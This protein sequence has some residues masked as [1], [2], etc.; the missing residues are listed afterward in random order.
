MNSHRLRFLASLSER[1][2]SDLA[3]R[4]RD[5]DDLT[6]PPWPEPAGQTGGYEPSLEEIAGDEVA[7][8]PTPRGARIEAEQDAESEFVAQ[9]GAIAP[10]DGSVHSE[11]ELTPHHSVPW[12]EAGMP[13][14]LREAIAS[15]R[16][17]SHEMH[18]PPAGEDTM[19]GPA[20][21]GDD[22]DYNIDPLDDDAAYE[23][24]PPDDRLARLEDDAGPEDGQIGSGGHTTYEEPPPDDE[25]DARARFQ[26]EHPP[27]DD[28][29]AYE[30]SQAADELVLRDNDALDDDGQIG[31]GAH[32][33][34]E[35]SPPEHAPIP[36]DDDPAY[37]H[38]QIRLDDD[39]AYDEQAPVDG[40]AYEP[41]GLE[42]GAAQEETP[43][44]EDSD[45]RVPLWRRA[46]RRYGLHAAA[47]AVAIAFVALAGF[48]LGVLSGDGEVGGPLTR[49]S[50]RAAAPTEPA[51]LST[52]QNT[53]VAERDRPAELSELVTVRVAPAP[54]TAV[55]ESAPPARLTVNAPL[56]PPPKPA[57]RQLAA[58]EA[59]PAATGEAAPAA[60]G[61]TAPA[62][63]GETAPAATDETAPAATGETA[64]A[65]TDETAPAATGETAPAA[66]GEAAPADRQLAGV[67]EDAAAALLEAE[68]AEGA[69]GPFQPLFTK[70]PAARPTA[71][72]V[73]VHYS[74]SA[75]GAPATAMHLVRHLKAEGFTVEARPV[76]F[77][78]PT[79]SIRYFFDADREQAEALR[80][81]LEG[82]VPGGAALSV[83][84][85]TSYEPKPRPGLI[86]VWLRA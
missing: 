22:A 69:G 68:G 29:A 10:I 79:N 45:D 65:A 46:K 84:D 30:E 81:R 24:P 25:L 85:F 54:V 9:P 70:L 37:Q 26:H 17:V 12:S 23:E 16:R 67:V 66:T 14:R 63:T 60:T 31:F 73:F 36:L 55:P 44:R 72:R 42:D 40:V 82:Q 21:F 61:E 57:L 1:L 20:P 18:E 11:G 13:V 38:E 83:M 77:S 48:G 51:H 15:V 56:P 5:S 27:L 76:E 58:D 32:A 49:D 39:A 47:F 6:P 2:Q 74:A 28:D 86:E 52:G 35:E 50:L 64:P 59:A 34:Y 8:P 41:M 3:S 7:G 71:T 4:E 78:I 53:P 33:G 62:A 43:G 75:V 80:S 19:H